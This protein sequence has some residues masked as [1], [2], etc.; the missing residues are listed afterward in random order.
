MQIQLTGKG[1][2]KLRSAL[3]VAEDKGSGR[4]AEYINTTFKERY[5]KFCPGKMTE[6]DLISKGGNDRATP[7]GGRFLK[8]RGFVYFRDAIRLEQPKM[9]PVANGRSIRWG[10]INQINNV[11]GFGWRTQWAGQNRRSE[12]RDTKGAGWNMYRMWEDGAEFTVYPRGNTYKYRTDKGV[13]KTS[14]VRNL[15]IAP[16]VFVKNQRKK[17]P[18]FRMTYHAVRQPSLGK[19]LVKQ[20]KQAVRNDYG[21]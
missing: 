5:L 16:G 6:G 12:W 9:V 15:H 8:E 13:E 4:I 7:G 14:T 17:I 3:K 2:N 1:R 19:E 18:R 11:S 21:S 20:V 10:D